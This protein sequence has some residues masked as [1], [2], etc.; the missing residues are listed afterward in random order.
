MATGT[1]HYESYGTFRKPWFAPPPSLF[2]PVWSVLYILILISFGT[3]F[4]QTIMRIWP[5]EI[6]LPFSVNLVANALFTPLQFRVR[7]NALAMLDIVAVLITIPWMML[8]IWPYAPWVALLQVPYLL[9]VCFATILQISITWLN[10]G[11]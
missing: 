10:R 7:S 11:R 1:M 8:W 4:W 2:G 3:V 6:A 5:A 9:W